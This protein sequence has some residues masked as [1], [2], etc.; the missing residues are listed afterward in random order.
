MVAAHTEHI[1]QPVICILTESIDCFPRF[2]RNRPTELPLL[3]AL[4]VAA[5][6]KNQ[7]SGQKLM[8]CINHT[9]QLMLVGRDEKATLQTRK[10][11]H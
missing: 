3:V 8:P 10:G 9:Y 7:L 1:S 6:S 11:I 5:E 4:T 2:D